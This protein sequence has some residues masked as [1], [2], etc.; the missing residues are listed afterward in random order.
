MSVLPEIDIDEI[1]EDLDIVDKAREAGGRDLPAT[2]ATALDATE[3]HICD[4]IARL[5]HD[6]RSAA[7][8]QVLSLRSRFA[9]IDLRGHIRSIKELPNYIRIEVDQALKKHQQNLLGLRVEERR[10]K[11]SLSVFEDKNN[12]HNSPAEYPDSKLFHWA[13]VAAMVFTE[14]VANS[15]FFAKGSDLG[16]IGGALQALLISA[17]NIGIALLAGNYLLRNLN[18]IDIARR[19][20]AGAGLAVYVAFVVAFNLATAHYRA[21]L[22]TDP[23]T[24]L[25]KTIPSL[26]R[27]PFSFDNFDATILLFIGILFAVA[28]MIKSYK[29]DSPYPGHGPLTRRHKAAV[30]LYNDA[31]QE[32]HDEAHEIIGTLSE[33]ADE[34][35]RQAKRDAF[36]QPV[37]IERLEHFVDEYGRYQSKLQDAQTALLKTYR[38]RNVAVRSNKPPA[39]F[40]TFPILPPEKPLPNID[41][42]ANR[43]IAAKA[44]GFLDQI[45]DEVG[46]FG[47]NLRKLYGDISADIDAFIARLEERA[48]DESAD[49]QTRPKT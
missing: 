38:E 19:M 15:Y 32:A 23:L 37:I 6:G 43:A 44:S 40:S 18:H 31:K 9:E 41:L 1:A 11:G 39:Y 16:L 34:I 4:R 47:T 17:V 24:A 21:L 25:L 20:I 3:Q 29:A 26:R 8:A 7:E 33:R 27:A 10:W 5:R 46:I 28:A 35:L 48:M 22:E 30:D 14:S 45:D 49:Q 13:V 42:D 12:L 36:E 2:G